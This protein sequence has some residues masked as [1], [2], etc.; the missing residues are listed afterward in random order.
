MSFSEEV[1]I[2]LEMLLVVELTVEVMRV[3]VD[4]DAVEVLLAVE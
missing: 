3:E 4:F 1:V 2:V